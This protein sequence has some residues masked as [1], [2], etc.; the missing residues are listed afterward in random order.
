M[1]FVGLIIYYG[2]LTPVLGRVDRVDWPC[3]LFFGPPRLLDKPAGVHYPITIAL[4]YSST[5]SG[6][7]PG[8]VRW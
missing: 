8:L 4:V 2:F 7:T 1:N 3:P 5:M 6:F